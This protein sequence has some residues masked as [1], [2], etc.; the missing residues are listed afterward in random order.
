MKKIFCTLFALPLL[1]QLAQGQIDRS[2]A[3]K[4]GPAPVIHI[5]T[6]DSFRLANGVRVFVVENHAIPKVTVSLVL[7]KDPVL[8]GD[9][10]GYVELTGE[11]MRRGTESRTKAQLDEDVDFLGGSLSTSSGS[12]WASSLTRNFDKL[13]AIFSDVV[14]HP[15]FRDSELTKLKTQTLSALEAQKDDPDAISDNVVSVVNFGKDYPYG[16]VVTDSTVSRVAVDDLK[17][18]YHTYWKPNICYM[19]FV[20]DITTAHARAL[21]TRYLSGWKRGVVPD[22]KYPV[23]DKPASVLV[24]VV[25]RPAA[26]QTNIHVTAPVILKPGNPENFPV[27]VMNHIL[28]GGPASWLFQDLREKHGFTY[29]AY[30]SIS[31]DPR[32]GSFSA[33]ASVRTA[34]T[35][36]AI[37][38][39]LYELRRIGQQ[40]VD[41]LV[42]DS[43]KNEISGNFALALENPA[44]IAQF[45]LNIARYHMPAD[46]YKNY[47]KSVAA[48]TAPDVEQAARQY[49][50]PGRVNIVLVGNAA[51]FA[52]SLSRFG[53]VQYVDMYGNPVKAP[54]KKEIPA[55]LT[56]DTVITRYLDAIG[57]RKKLAA[58]HD[59][60]MDLEARM[61]GQPITV[62][63]RYL[64][65]GYFDMVMELATQHMKVLKVLVAGDSVQME[66]RGTRVPINEDRRQ[67]LLA[68]AR[69]FAELNFLDGKHTVKLVGITSLNGRDAYQVDVAD[70]ANTTSSYYFDAESG[71][72]VRSVSQEEG[73]SGVVPRITD[74]GDYQPT[75][76]ILFPHAIGSQMGNQ[77]IQ[78][79]VKDVKIN[80]GLTPAD[81]K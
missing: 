45:A 19:A 11:M 15:A 62:T 4:A 41:Q 29:G 67:E 60:T 7:K 79:K 25:D 1:F 38:R 69:P 73:P 50:T 33:S 77:T 8:E 13:F 63:R 65:P 28:G 30:S 48:V 75:D 55:S 71:L 35:D 27:K 34:V 72:K 14:L 10:A 31:D 3:P 9:K 22:K 39:F 32:V 61:M 47:L 37:V 58:V 78:M 80:S 70:T 26:V 18:Y 76:G 6:A 2:V 53:K 40:Q 64:V 54:E 49:V 23:P 12:A 21:A 52:D 5:G 59:M 42:L 81:F 43:A 16:E 57:G 44:L 17:G 68:E 36:S 56:A 51:V 24:T 66:S 46:Y 20:G 74:L